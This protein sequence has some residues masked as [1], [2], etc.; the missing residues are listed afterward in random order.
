MISLPDTTGIDSSYKAND[1]GLLFYSLVKVYRP[2]IVCELGSY[3]GY[4][5]LHIAAAMRDNNQSHR[6]LNLID[7]WDQ[8]AFKHCSLEAIH[9]NFARDGLHDA[10]WRWINFINSNANVAYKL[11]RDHSVDML[12]IDI[13]NDGT[14]LAET[15]P[16]W[17]PKLADGALVIVE[18]GSFQR[19]H[20][21]WMEMYD[22]ASIQGWL[23]TMA[24][25]HQWNFSPFPS[26]TMLRRKT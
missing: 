6:Q 12:H 8:Y 22:K 7:L 19:D 25:W 26:V 16:L 13:S 4:S 11:F 23:D 5:A 21:E 14:K 17:E 9:A 15:F 2:K 1:Y 18:G 20:V 3:Q 10:N 24:D